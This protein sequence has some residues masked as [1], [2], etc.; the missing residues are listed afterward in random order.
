MMRHLGIDLRVTVDKAALL[1]D[2]RRNRATHQAMVAEARAG[3]IDAALTKLAAAQAEL[4]AGKVASLSFKLP[5]PKDFTRVYDTTIGQ[6]EAHTGDTLTL[7]TSEYNMLVEDEW[8]WVR[9]FIMANASYSGS[10]RAWSATK[11]FE[12]E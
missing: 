3:Y 8:E 5:V 6:I 4:K 9:D 2:L 1:A 10:T 7:S 12:V 11:N